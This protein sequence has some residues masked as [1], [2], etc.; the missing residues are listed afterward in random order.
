MVSSDEA[1]V[2]VGVG[3]SQD[4]GP[5]HVTGYVSVPDIDKALATVTRLGGSVVAPK[6][7]PDGAAPALFA[8]P[9]AT[10]SAS[11]KPEP[12]P[13]LPAPDREGT[14]RSL[15]RCQCTASTAPLRSCRASPGDALGTRPSR[16]TLPS[17]AGLGRNGRQSSDGAEGS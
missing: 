2:W 1:G 7:S 4:G 8:D 13:G 3:A 10:S 6:F 5:G 15:V 11:A 9:Q 17:H 12:T 16:P 14:G